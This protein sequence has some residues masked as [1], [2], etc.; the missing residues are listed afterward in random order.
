MCGFSSPKVRTPK[1][2]PPP[3]PQPPPEV[4]EAPTVGSE[5]RA[6]ES[7]RGKRRTGSA[8]LRIGLNVPGAKGGSGTNL[9]GA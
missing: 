8:K 5:R 1:P 2:P 3:K 6:E 4:A 7:R 9:P